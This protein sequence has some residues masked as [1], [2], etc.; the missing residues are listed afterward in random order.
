MSILGCSADELGEVLRA[1]GFRSEKRVRPAPVKAV[2]PTSEAG[3]STSQEAQSVDDNTGQPPQ[4]TTVEGAETDIAATSG[5]ESA[6]TLSA[7][8][9]SAPTPVATSTDA[10]AN[11]DAPSPDTPSPDTPSPDTPSHDT[12]VVHATS[13]DQHPDGVTASTGT[14]SNGEAEA[15]ADD[16]IAHQSELDDAQTWQGE[17]ATEAMVSEGQASEIPAFE[18][19]DDGMIEVWRPRRRHEGNRPR[20]RRPRQGQ[21]AASKDKPDTTS[22]QR[23]GPD[24]HR[25]EA[26]GNQQPGDQ[27]G[28]GRKGKGGGKPGQRGDRGRTDQGGRKPQVV[29]AGP[30]KAEKAAS[31][32]SPFAALVAL[33]ESME[34][35]EKAREK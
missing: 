23:G 7:Q 32:S 22:E 11:A 13:A 14:T 3:A 8:T 26:S 35:K 5:P 17:R 15:H 31:E 18:S 16:T 25:R 4:P 28:R 10:P 6:Q 2:P 29:S 24:R 33:K 1:L 21:G 34:D 20:G 30:K 9:L 27:R 19:Q 12:S